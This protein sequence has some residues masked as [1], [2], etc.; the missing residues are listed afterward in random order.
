RVVIASRESPIS[1]DMPPGIADKNPMNFGRTHLASCAARAA[2][3]LL[4]SVTTTIA[5]S[6]AHAACNL[7][8]GLRSQFVGALGVVDRP[9]AGP[10]E[11]VEVSLRECDQSAGL[12]A[13]AA[14]HTVTVVFTPPSTP[15]PFLSS[16]SS[17]ART[18][19][20]G[21]QPTRARSS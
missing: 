5:P 8:P 10:G 12:S 19:N 2:L 1:L 15:S 11:P 18:L 13:N 16:S 6:S 3:V 21:R 4:L 9:F 14:D 17:R 7:I 20:V